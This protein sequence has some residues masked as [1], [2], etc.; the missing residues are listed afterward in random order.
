MEAYIRKHSDFSKHMIE[1]YGFDAVLATIS[2]ENTSIIAK[3]DEEV[4]QDDF[5]I[6]G[7]F[8]GVIKGISVTGNS[9]TLTCAGMDEAF[10]RTSYYN[11]ST[12]DG[13]TAEELVS[14]LLKFEYVY[15]DSLYAM[16][17]LDIRAGGGTALIKPSR[18][19]YGLYTM[20]AYLKKLRK[21]GINIQYD[22][23]G[24]K[25]V[26]SFA[27]YP[28][29]QAS[30][31]FVCHN[32]VTGE[33]YGGFTVTKVTNYTNG[34][35]TDYYLLSDGTVTNDASAENRVYG[36]WEVTV[37]SEEDAI[38]E[39]FAATYGHQ[40]L[41]H[42]KEKYELYTPLRLRM[43]SGKMLDSFISC[44]GVKSN[45]SHYYYTAG[46]LRTTLTAKL[47]K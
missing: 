6:C 14:A 45:D 7:E 21:K 30:I 20:T 29:E 9:M 23:T 12:T 35:P 18:N 22:L 5:I 41:F 32:T 19:E 24:D 2:D 13:M 26:I 42:S 38:L 33:T 25:L 27:K 34:V 37:N 1:V 40:I 17:Y 46:E 16:P 36:S 15:C 44:V 8:S 4:E 11:V 31:D 43:P 39:K 28:T 10:S 47:R 3:Y